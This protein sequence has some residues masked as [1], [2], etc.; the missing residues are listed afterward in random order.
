MIANV[1]VERHLLRAVAPPPPALPVARLVDD[2]AVD[3]GAERRLA[4]EGVNGAEDPQEDF[5]REVERFVVVAQQVERQ[6]VDHAL[7][8]GD[9]LGAGVLVAR[10]AA[11]N[12]Q[13]LAAADVRPGNGSNRLH[14]Q[15][16][17]HL[18][19]RQQ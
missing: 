16:F 6:L 15:S 19:T 7:V 11:L 1:L 2:D 3:P 18:I 17:R 4:A 8:L 12:Q 14:G 9:Q 5:L 13:R 10:G